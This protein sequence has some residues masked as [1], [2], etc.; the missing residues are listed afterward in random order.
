MLHPCTCTYRH[1][2]RV[3]VTHGDPLYCEKVSSDET[4]GP[5]WPLPR[6]IISPK[7]HGFASRRIYELHTSQSGTTWMDI[8][9]MRR[10]GIQC[11]GSLS[12]KKLCYVTVNRD[13]LRTAIAHRDCAPIVHR[14]RTDCLPTA[15]RL[16]VLSPRSF[17]PTRCATVRRETLS[18]RVTRFF[19]FRCVRSTVCTCRV[20]H[21][22]WCSSPPRQM[23]NS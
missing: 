21:C 11:S 22:S 7:L 9:T 14:L 10:S 18:A 12:G 1:S 5:D 16:R 6:T 2:R 17:M 13:R 4:H 23:R 8:R 20:L 15:R 3:R 19:A